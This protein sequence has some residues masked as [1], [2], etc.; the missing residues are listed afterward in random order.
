MS[1]RIV[2]TQSNLGLQPGEAGASVIPSAHQLTIRDKCFRSKLYLRAFPQGFYWSNDPS[3]KE[4][5]RMSAGHEECR[6]YYNISRGLARFDSEK[7]MTKLCIY[8]EQ[9]IDVK[10]HYR[11]LKIIHES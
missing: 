5:R 6:Q 4:I 2:R 8:Q 1:L 9:E 7:Q 11:K 10:A 3:L